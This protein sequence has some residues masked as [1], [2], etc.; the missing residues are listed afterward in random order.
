MI[1]VVAAAGDRAAVA[2]G[3]RWRGHDVGV[4]TPSDLSRP[5]WRVA[6]DEPGAGRAVVEGEVVDVAAITG[7]LTRLPAVTARD[8]AHVHPDDRSYAA[9]EMN[10][11]LTYWL[12]VLECPVVNRPSALSLCGPSWRP[13]QW[14]RAA[15]SAGFQVRPRLRHVPPFGLTA[16]AHEPQGPEPELGAAQVATVV[17]DRCLGADDGLAGPA[18]ALAARAGVAV[19]TVAARP[20][21]DDSW[22]FDQAHVWTDLVRPEGRDAVLELVSEGRP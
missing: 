14:S 2:I 22:W 7:V 13:E 4:L 21:T 10:A 17:G 3:R 19:M 12:T 1:V 9:A 5:G 8:L 11:F 6:A 18:L 16:A 15:A 20:A